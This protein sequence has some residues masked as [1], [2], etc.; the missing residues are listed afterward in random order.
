MVSSNL[1]RLGGLL[2]MLGGVLHAALRLG[3]PEPL[4]R[5]FLNTPE[6]VPVDYYVDLIDYAFTTFLLPLG[7]LSS[8]AALHALQGQRY[9]RPGALASLISFA[10]LAIL[11]GGLLLGGVS[12]L[13]SEWLFIADQVLSVVII[14][15]LAATAG[16]VALGIV[17][18]AARVLPWW[19]G[20]AIIAGSPPFAWLSGPLAGVA[21][22]LVGYAIFRAGAQ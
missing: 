5:W 4:V 17:T 2:A 16:L 18:M 8:I 21:W 10:G 13:R 14:G 20:M 6:P 12:A 1:I 7:A 15:F 3:L 22:A 19:C 11:V 9:G